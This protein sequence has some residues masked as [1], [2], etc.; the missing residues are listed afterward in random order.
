[1][2]GVSTG[3]PRDMG[4]FALAIDPSAFIPA[5]IYEGIMTRYLESI[6]ARRPGRRRRRPADG[7]GDRELGRG[8]TERLKNGIPRRPPTRWR[9]MEQLSATHGLDAAGQGVAAERLE[10]VRRFRCG[11][12]AGSSAAQGPR[13]GCGAFQLASAHRLWQRPGEP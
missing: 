13:P 8:S 12:R 5:L 10:A 6:R 9:R 11:R 1:M 3:R 4:G 2:Y 7:S